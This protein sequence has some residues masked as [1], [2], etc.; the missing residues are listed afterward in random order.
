M[1]YP[2]RQEVQQ[3]VLYR[4]LQGSRVNGYKAKK[5][6]FPGWD[7]NEAA[8]RASKAVRHARGV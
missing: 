6:G 5:Y 1:F 3:Y 4:I 7:Y 8:G 2:P